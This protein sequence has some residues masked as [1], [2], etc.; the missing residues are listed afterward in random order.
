M[1]AKRRSTRKSA[2]Y[3]RAKPSRKKSARS[4]PVHQAVRA[5]PL[6]ESLRCPIVGV[7]G[8][9]VGF[10]AARELLRHLPSHTG[11]AFVIVEHLNPHQASRL[12]R[13]LGKV[14]T[15][16]LIELTETKSV[17]R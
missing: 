17:A 6:K 5:K 7:G 4:K 10:A 13:L 3:S 16:P 12:P 15:A 14:T 9:A 1:A 2:S 8:S 11:M